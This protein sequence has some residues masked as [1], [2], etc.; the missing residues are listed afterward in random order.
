MKR[1]VFILLLL[2][3]SRL[4]YASH[5]IG[6]EMYYKYLGS[7]SAGNRQYTIYLKLYRGCDP[8]GPN[9]ADFDPSITISIFDRA[10]NQFLQ[11]ISNIPLQSRTSVSLTDYDPCIVNPPA[12]CYQIGYYQ[13]TVTLPEN[14]QGYL[15]SYQRCC[16]NAKLTNVYANGV[17]ATY[18]TELPGK[19]YGILGNNSAVFEKEKAVLICA[20]L[21]F[22]YDYSATDP[23]GD[24]LSYSFAEA[25]TGGGTGN[26][27]P[28]PS[29]PP[30]YSSL[31]YASPFSAA[32]PMGD[33]V[34]I[35]P[36]TGVISGKA[37]SAGTYVLTVMAHEFRKGVEIAQHRKD[38]HITVTDCSKAVVASLPDRFNNC[39]G[40]A[41][42]FVNNSTQGKTYQ[43][44]F[45]DG[46][47]SDLFQPLHTYRDT[48]TY[49][50]RLRV[51][52]QSNCGDS[53]FTTVRVY[54]VLE[55]RL[56]NIGNCTAKPTQFFDQ[57]RNAYG[58]ID[59]RR[60]DF[61][62]PTTNAD[63]A[64]VPNPSYQYKSAGT[65]K[66]TL[67]I[68]TTKGCEASFQQDIVIYDSPSLSVTNDT[69]ICNTDSIRLKAKA[70]VSGGSYAWN[71]SYNI[72]NSNTAMPTVFPRKDTSYRVLFTDNSGCTATG[73]VLVRVKSNLQVFAGND[74]SLCLG[75][76]L[77][78]RATSNDRYAFTWYD[79]SNNIVGTGLNVKV[80]PRYNNRYIIFARLGNCESS[81]TM[82]AKVTPYPAAN[83]GPD[84][85]ICFGEAAPLKATGGSI[86]RWSPARDLSQPNISNPIAYPLSTTN[87]VVTVMDTL[88][89][90][91]AVNDTIQVRVVPPVNAFAGNDTILT[92][93]QVLQLHASGGNY[94]RWSP[95]IGL[96]DPFIP[97]PL[98]RNN[99]DI[100]YFL[101][102]ST[103]EGCKGYDTLHIK[104]INGP[105]IY[106]P[107]AFSPN[108]DGV[109]DVFR[110]IPVG[111]TQ[112][113]LFKV[114]DR[115]GNEVYSSTAYLKGWDGQYKGR[116][117]P[118]G[119]YV[120]LARGIDL[121]GKTI[122]RKG[123]VILIR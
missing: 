32:T 5:I 111:I 80:M 85:S 14:D 97:D 37:P 6:G 64:V 12:V 75:D 43:W 103:E 71:P 110:P 109:N 49:R 33:G 9:N 116:P 119:T 4:S 106:V 24:S 115:W 100:T 15:L 96:S 27:A 35:N 122:F 31:T 72:I 114:F 39:D 1:S 112:M 25:Y 101:T 92:R 51:D 46:T 66:I 67:K 118:A 104:Y 16:R 11:L 60:W 62:D 19:G 56:T 59:S 63:T 99:Q 55:P 22:T 20:K 30:P 105:E 42:Q 40:F 68:T 84:I 10:T 57:S 29:S 98:V 38:I 93:G 83:A 45:G 28:S 90:P 21:P 73:N 108:G 65:Y 54:P 47:S 61:G 86:Y 102:V 52:P 78:L 76:T 58:T 36:R 44:D 120:W 95:P 77:P 87:Y 123:T 17:G 82:Y 3:V 53:A 113:E 2:A 91:K 70:I 89:C 48:G 88:G 81:D 34:T 79:G 121:T 117:A 8:P 50:V 7:P 107:N 26:N 94:Y 13:T 74:T 41:I 23:D 69:L 18:V